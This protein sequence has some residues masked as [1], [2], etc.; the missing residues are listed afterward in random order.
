ME[1][2]YKLNFNDL[3]RFL[4]DFSYILHKGG[5][6]KKLSESFNMSSNDKTK[7]F[8]I[9]WVEIIIKVVITFIQL[10][11][12][13]VAIYTIYIII[14]KGYPRVVIDLLT[15]QFYNK[16]NQDDFLKE[17]NLLTDQFKFLSKDHASC[18]TPFSI[19]ES[20]YGYTNLNTLSTT[21]EQIKDKY[22]SKYKYNDK[23]FNALKEYYLFYDKINIT[24]ARDVRFKTN[25]IVIKKY[26]AYELL[27]TYKIINGEII[28]KNTEG[29][30][31]G[32]DQQMY[33]LYR[34][35]E[36]TQFNTIKGIEEIH[37]VLYKMTKEIQTMNTNFI[38]KPI[39]PY[40]IIPTDD[41]AIG[42]ILKD[43]SKFKTNILNNTIY[44]I[45][46]SQLSDYSWYIIEYI[47]S[48]SNQNQY[49]S[50]V[51]NMPQYREDISKIIYY[52]NLPREDKIIAENR[53]MNYSQNK[54]FFEYIKKR[55][56]FA[57][58]YFS[59]VLK[60]KAVLYSNVMNTYKLLGD[61]GN[62]VNI[63]DNDIA[64]MKKRLINLQING[65]LFKQLAN[66]VSFMNL[67]L[68]VYRSNM[69]NIYEKQIISNNR[70]LKELWVPFFD[71]IFINRIG[72]FTK[73]TFSSEGMGGSYG[74]FLKFYKQLGVE[75]NRMIKAVFMA[76]FT[77][78]PQEKPKETD[79]DDGQP[80]Q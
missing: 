30:E 6:G 35:E 44:N 2:S 32:T 79:T 76:F 55:P 57:H 54:L 25:K 22:Y 51:L 64:T 17:R 9:K 68:S 65:Y 69:T 33:E 71:D 18:L 12:I 50:F 38:N 74:R 56:I 29:G 43:F 52:I 26:D 37:S 61:C 78:T 67:F 36:K 5:S 66:T 23:Y 41:K 63:N 4:Q 20:I 62:P 77:S 19:Y 48:L 28:T 75:L 40:L 3:S 47:L 7:N 8:I 21:F 10:C 59:R 27:L 49:N 16:E 14:F 1:S 45:S 60:D 80:A 58:I 15:F 24:N 46:Y 73:K 70:F 53:V 42:I 11:L 31:K 34:A 39:I 72:N 13:V